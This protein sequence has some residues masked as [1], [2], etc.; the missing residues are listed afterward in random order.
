MDFYAVLDQ[1]VTLLQQRGRVSYQ[2]LKRQFNLD[3]AYIDDLKIELIDAQQVARDDNGRV[4]VWIGEAVASP[5]GN[6]ASDATSGRADIAGR[7]GAASAHATRC[8]PA[9]DAERRQLTVMF[10]DLVGSTALAGQLDPEDSARSSA[11]IRLPARRSSSATRAILPSIWA[12]ACWSTS[13]IPRPMK[14]M[15]S[16]PCAPGWGF[17]RRCGAER[18]SGTR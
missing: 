4:L 1:I 9:A 2:A 8:T 12:T 6:T 7:P 3:D 15:L 13:A 14:T 18:A 16:A 11:P 17:S 5:G 10:C